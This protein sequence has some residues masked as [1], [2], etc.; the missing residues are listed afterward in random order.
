MKTGIL[1][2]TD[3][4]KMEIYR[5][6]LISGKYF[7]LLYLYKNWK[8]CTFLSYMYSGRAYSGHKILIN[9]VYKEISDSDYGLVSIATVFQIHCLCFI[10]FDF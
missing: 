1:I 7:W 8:M 9:F 10:F 6:V 5:I 2:E 4:Q 3:M